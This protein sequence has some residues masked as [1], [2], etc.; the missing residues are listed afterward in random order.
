MSRQF[1]A[2]DISNTVSSR[3]S[4][5]EMR[6]PV[7]DRAEYRCK[8][9]RAHITPKTSVLSSEFRGTSGRAILCRDARNVSL[10]PVTLLLM[11]SGAYRVQNSSCSGCDT[12]I[13]WRFVSAT[14]KTEQWKE[15]HFILELEYLEEELMPLS[16]LDKPTVELKWNRAS[17]LASEAIHKRS[18]SSASITNLKRIRPMGPRARV[19]VEA[20]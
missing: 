1:L 3:R 15:G 17:H 14:E 16:P 9:C 19:T 5:P 6:S 18:H 20:C 4:M 10:A 12:I 13:G 7:S 2:V 11:N 8:S